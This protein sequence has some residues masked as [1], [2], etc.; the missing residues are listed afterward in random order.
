MIVVVTGSRDGVLGGQ[1]AVDQVLDLIPD[2]R[3]LIHGAATGADTLAENWARSREIDYSGNPARWKTEGNRLAGPIRNG[4]ML[5]RALLLA[6]RLHDDLM[7]VAFP[8]GTGTEGCVREAHRLGI[9]VETP[10][11]LRDLYGG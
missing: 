1:D 4:R 5:G 8:G 9:R 2:V 10:I 7:L 3:L 6:Q 11:T